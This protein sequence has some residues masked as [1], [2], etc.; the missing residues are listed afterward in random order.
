MASISAP[1]REMGGIGPV[2][3]DPE[4]NTSNRYQTW[5]SADL[6]PDDKANAHRRH[7]TPGT[8]QTAEKVAA[9][10]VEFSAAAAQ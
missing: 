6:V 1:A 7:G 10:V 5:A 3:P 9:A 8:D 2:D 4:A